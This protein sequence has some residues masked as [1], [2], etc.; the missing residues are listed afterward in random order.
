M[1][2]RTFSAVAIVVRSVADTFSPKAAIRS[3]KVA[4]NAFSAPYTSSSSC[5]MALT[6]RGDDA[7][8]RSGLGFGDAFLGRRGDA[9]PRRAR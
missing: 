3:A 7:R 4:T 2:S 6:K 8:G 1:V 9:F 5:S